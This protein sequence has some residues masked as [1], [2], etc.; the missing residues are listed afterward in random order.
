MPAFIPRHGGMHDGI[1]LHR[2]GVFNQYPA[3]VTPRDIQG[4]VCNV[5]GV[6]RDDL[7]SV[8]RGSA[9]SSRGPSCLTTA[10]HVAIWLTLQITWLSYA[11]VAVHFQRADHTTIRN[12]RQR[13]EVLMGA[14]QELRRI[15][16]LICRDLETRAAAGRNCR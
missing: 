8:R 14:S 11:Q 5:F 6:S 4:C 16:L 1:R 12:A 13:A 2:P 10:R 7:M 9:V 3:N 15:V